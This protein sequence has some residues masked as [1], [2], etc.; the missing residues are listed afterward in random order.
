MLAATAALL[1]VLLGAPSVSAQEAFPAPIVAG[2]LPAEGT[3]APLA[4]TS[5]RVEGG[6]D[7]RTLVVAFA[8][9]FEMPDVA[10]YRVALLL[11]AA[12]APRQRLSLLA[13]AGVATGV[14]ERAERPD[15]VSSGAT[16]VALDGAEVRI[17]L[18]D[19][20]VVD[21]DALAWVEAAL[22]EAEGGEAER[23]VTPLFPALDLLVGSGPDLDAA[24]MA[25]S[26]ATA[27]P[28]TEAVDT[29]AAPA[30]R[31]EDEEIVVTFGGDIPTSVGG[32]P[33]ASVVDVVRVASGFSGGALAPYLIA[34]DHDKGTITLLDGTQALPVEVETDGSWILEDLPATDVREG[35]EVVFELP[36]VLSAF[37]LPDAADATGVGVARSITLDSG[38]V[39]R[40]DGPVATLAWYAEGGAPTPPP[41]G[42]VDPATGSSAIPG[43]A[44]D[45]AVEGGVEQG[46]GDGASAADGEGGRSV[47]PVVAVAC[48][49]I[50]L[51]AASWLVVRWLEHRRQEVVVGPAAERRPVSPSA[52]ERARLEAFT[53]E[54]FGAS[55]VP[56]APAPTERAEPPDTAALAQALAQAPGRSAQ[57]RATRPD[58]ESAPASEPGRVPDAVTSP[59]PAPA[60]PE[61]APAA[62]EPE[63]ASASPS[64]IEL[65]AAEPL[66]SPPPHADATV[67]STSDPKA[68]DAPADDASADDA[69]ADEAP[70]D[71]A[72]SPLA[73]RSSD[74]PARRR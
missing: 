65:L 12:D 24:S 41:G 20:L 9:P 2:V 47:L 25:W 44:T 8:A 64:F 11:G 28:P 18:P 46:A 39:V 71:E 34:I 26:S 59:E 60:V 67:A 42:A 6:A 37:G 17:G 61:P 72:S 3:P 53:S 68:E 4:V 30:V 54:L 38:T 7:G 35:T 13:E 36:A 63:L 1:V 49:V 69:S 51:G 15:W 16:E 21:A 33:V 10:R 66:A 58:T 23:F 62:P 32:Q 73:L 43:T 48:V 22:V 56:A 55:A 45:G 29:G 57:D 74:L 19:D 31:V 52:D 5:L 14:V 27:Q 50:L 40:A 70:A